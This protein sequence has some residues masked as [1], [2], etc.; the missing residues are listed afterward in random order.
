MTIIEYRAI[1]SLAEF[2]AAEALQFLVW[3]GSDIETV[4]T[5]ILRTVRENGGVVHGAFARVPG[6]K[7]TLVGLVF[8]F[9]GISKAG[10]LLHCSDLLCVHPDYRNLDIG[11]QLKLIQ[12]RV[13]LTQGIDLITW[14]FDPLESRNA[15]LNFHKLGGISRTYLC[16]YYGNMKDDLNTSLPSDRLLLEWAIT[17]KKVK[18][19]ISGEKTRQ[20]DNLTGLKVLNPSSQDVLP[21]P[22]ENPE[23]SG[24]VSFL[25]ELPGNFREILAADAGLALAWRNHLRKLFSNSFSD[26]YTIT[27]FSYDKK[28]GRGYYLLE[29]GQ[30]QKFLS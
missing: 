13:V 30:P 25:V 21:R 9:P 22:T 24:D 16:D 4:P 7:E 18:S 5:H 1:N 27:N 23:M 10:K 17:S 6:G 29:K 2:Q 8:G 14:T 15:N 26:G 19:L 11:Y 12:R 3:G 20:M 28:N